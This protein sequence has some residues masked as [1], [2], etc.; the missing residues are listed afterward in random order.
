MM[1]LDLDW[2]MVQR[3]GLDDGSEIWIG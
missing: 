2:M 1:V 3:F